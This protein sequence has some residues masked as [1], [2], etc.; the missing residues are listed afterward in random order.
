MK[1]FY[2]AK[3]IKLLVFRLLTGTNSF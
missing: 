2:S 1:A 3:E